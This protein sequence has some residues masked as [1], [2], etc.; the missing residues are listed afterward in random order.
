MPPHGCAAAE[1]T[2]TEASITIAINDVF[3]GIACGYLRGF[4]NLL[5]FRQ[6]APLI[7]D[8]A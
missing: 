3:R 1:A 6:G 2:L 4:I 7:T 5:K 8:S